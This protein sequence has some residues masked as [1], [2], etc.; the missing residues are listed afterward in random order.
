MLWLLLALQLFE[1]GDKLRPHMAEA[2]EAADMAGDGA[3]KR[4]DGDA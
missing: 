2:A 4:G 1:N 3:D